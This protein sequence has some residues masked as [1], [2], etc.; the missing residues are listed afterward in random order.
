MTTR[1][2]EPSPT[3]SAWFRTRD[4]IIAIASLL[5]IVVHLIAGLLDYSWDI[6]LILALVL[7]GLPLIVELVKSMLRLDFG[8]DLLAGIS[9]IVS[10]IL[11][12]Y[13]AGAIVVLM[14]S[15]GE[16][17]E[18]YAIGR[19]SAALEALATR[20]PSTAHRARA[21]GTIVDVDIS[22]VSVGD[23]VVVYPNETC[24]VDGT[25]VSGISSMDESY[26][27]GEPFKVR[28]T[29]GAAVIS[30]AVN[31]EGALHV[32]ADA[33]AS[34]SRYAQIMA[35]MEEAQQ[36]RP[37]VRRL[38]DK[39]GAWYTPL[40]L[41]IAACAWAGSGD[42]IRFLA[43]LVVATPCPLLISIPV[44]LIGA[45]SMA[46]RRSIV[47]RDTTILEQL[48]RCSTLILDKTGTLTL[49]TPE[50]IH[51]KTSDVLDE[52]T[53][54]G[55]AAS[56]EQYSTHPLARALIEAAEA[57]GV[58]LTPVTNVSEKPGT[59][60]N[61][62]IAGQ[63]VQLTSRK[64]L[65]EANHCDA[66]SL[67]ETEGG[68]ESVLLVDGRYACTFVFHDKPRDEGRA[69]IEHLMPR[70]GIERVMIVSGDRES[71]VQY[72]ADK[73]GIST[74]FS[75][76]SPEQKVSIVK[77]EE[78]RARVAFVGD[79]IND[80]PAL[81]LASAGIAMGHGSDVTREAAGAVILD[82]SLRRIDELFHIASRFRTIALQSAVG[83]IA[84]SMFG[85]GFAAFG[86]LTPVAGAILQEGI[87][88][89]SI[90]NA[91]RVGRGGKA[92]TDF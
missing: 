40:A 1:Q 29:T 13:L 6:P 43:V 47:I 39:L 56:L 83:G 50:L 9:I 15:G 42:P 36:H 25:V 59:G 10:V 28:K 37:R 11:G 63:L 48:P 58:S 70:H 45:V 3:R 92:L 51:T 77:K 20:L 79:G 89:L 4:G 22:E 90:L 81:M 91:L 7:G 33:V 53:L 86:L 62:V 54:I 57:R 61:G 64:K 32:L 16:T 76:Q 67:P 85:M 30:G 80:A 88:L 52:E 18:A 44:A 2:H 72:L 23:T 66:A 35:V 68:L 17:L 49:G 78:E 38:A 71:E 46:A 82:P 55:L 84:L 41:L 34:D 69:Y 14:L 19:A 31:G 5:A 26:L 87:D 65:V 12:E 60:L 8:A 74:T 73:V 24:P 27:T 21:D 75:G